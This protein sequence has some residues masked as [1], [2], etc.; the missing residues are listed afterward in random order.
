MK[1]LLLIF[2][3]GSAMGLQAGSVVISSA[4]GKT[5]AAAS[6]ATLPTG[7][8]VRIGTFN[9][10]NATRDQTLRTT[11][12]YAQLKA[13]FKPL[14]EGVIG[15]GSPSQMDGAGTVLRNN[16][17]PAAGDIFGTI[18]DISATYM[19]QG[20]QLY[21]W[22]FDSATPD[23]CNQWGLFSAATW[24]APPSLGTQTLSTTATVNALQGSVTSTQL[25]LS[26]VPS[27]YGNWSWKAYSLT[28]ASN[29]ISQVADPDNDGLANIAEYAWKLN[30]AARD[31]AITTLTANVSTGAKFTF[32]SP[33]GTPD[34]AVTAECSTDLLSWQ[35]AP[36][37]II[38]SDADFDT[39]ECSVAPG[40]RCFWR[41]RFDPVTAQ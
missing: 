28:A 35:P 26:N 14:A 8:T 11:F 40:T 36:S 25:R 27:T 5:F 19:P 20:T 4:G 10:P 41:V 17:F 12:D 32:K 39:R 30:P 9:L 38:A 16:A 21:V 7:T 34:V 6:G 13:W 1:R 2:F 29:V 18:S 3:V 23:N 24:G 31:S 37:T 33:R 15:G 22:V